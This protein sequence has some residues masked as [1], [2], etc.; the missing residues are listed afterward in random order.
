M[1]SGDVH[2]AV[3][4]WPNKQTYIARGIADDKGKYIKKAY[5]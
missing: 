2:A 1:K 3:Y 4:D 5:E